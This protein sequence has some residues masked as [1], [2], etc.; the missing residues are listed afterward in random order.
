MWSISQRGASREVDS[1][2]MYMLSMQMLEM[3]CVCLRLVGWPS[4]HNPPAVCALS[5]LVVCD[6]IVDASART[7]LYIIIHVLVRNRCGV[8]NGNCTYGN[9]H[10]VASMHVGA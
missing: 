1:T 7:S 10:E 4:T 6:V 5:S 8:L 9:T 3:Q 2:Y